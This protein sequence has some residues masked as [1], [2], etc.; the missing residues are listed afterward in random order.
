MRDVYAEVGT[1]SAGEISNLSS[2]LAG[3]FAEGVDLGPRGDHIRSL[4]RSLDIT[5]AALRRALIEIGEPSG[6]AE[7]FDLLDRLVPITRAARSYG[8]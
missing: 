5:I 4:G 2:A 3:A 1:M 8:H 6:S 7:I